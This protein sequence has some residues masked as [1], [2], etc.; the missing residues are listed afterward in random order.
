MVTLLH[1]FV[2]LLFDILHCRYCETVVEFPC[3]GVDQVYT[4]RQNGVAG[5]R[6]VSVSL[7]QYFTVYTTELAMYL[8]CINAEMNTI[9]NKHAHYVQYTILSEQFT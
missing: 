6:Q 5:Q 1:T 8:V 3:Y 9:F 4:C 7:I 2:H